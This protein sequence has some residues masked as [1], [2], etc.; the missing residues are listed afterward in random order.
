MLRAAFAAVNA[1]EN[2]A[3][4]EYVYVR[5]RGW[6]GPPTG[7]CAKAVLMLA[8]TLGRRHSSIPQMSARAQADRHL[9]GHDTP[10]PDVDHRRRGFAVAIVS[11]CAVA[12]ELVQC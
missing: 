9:D 7:T 2:D 8:R 6:R 12:R 11:V 3:F 5:A 4:I 1:F 10:E